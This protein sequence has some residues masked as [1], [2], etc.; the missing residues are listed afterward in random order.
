MTHAR[1]LPLKGRSPMEATWQ[2]RR[3]LDVLA[4]RFCFLRAGARMTSEKPEAW[5]GCCERCGKPGSLSWC[6]VLTRGAWK[7]RW[8]AE[9][10]Y[11]W[12]AGCHRYFDQHWDDKHEWIVE[13]IGADGF[14]ML[15]LR[16]KARGS[17]DYRGK[18]ILLE[19]EIAR[20]EAAA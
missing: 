20:I 8:D 13:R 7:V 18:I 4:R 9:N 3:V 11:A 19:R 12:C 15:R 1:P 16:K 14:Q 5:E 6:H 2:D 17:I 10:S